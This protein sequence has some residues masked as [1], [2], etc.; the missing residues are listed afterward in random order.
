[1]LLR[2]GIRVSTIFSPEKGSDVEALSIVSIFVILL[3]DLGAPE[4]RFE[5]EDF[6]ELAFL[7]EGRRSPLVI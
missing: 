1:V 6:V 5:Y 4:G 3:D 7:E 2:R